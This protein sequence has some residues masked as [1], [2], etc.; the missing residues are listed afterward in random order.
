MKPSWRSVAALLLASSLLVS[1]ALAVAPGNKRQKSAGSSSNG[2][3]ARGRGDRNAQIRLQAAPLDMRI[4]ARKLQLEVLN[5]N[6]A[7]PGLRQQIASARTD[8]IKRAAWD[9]YYT[10]LYGEMR[11]RSPGLTEYIALLEKVA[12]S[13]Y[14]SPHRRGEALDSAGFDRA[15]L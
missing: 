9:R 12:R 5:S 11:R 1:Q 8:E 13:R 14:D 2:N 3:N 4:S 15:E 7:F 6:A 10:I